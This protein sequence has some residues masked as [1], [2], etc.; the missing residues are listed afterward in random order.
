MTHIILKDV[1]LSFPHKICFESFSAQ[2]PFGSRIGIIGINGSGKSTL[3][4]IIHREEVP[5]DGIL[6]I[7]DDIKTA[8]VPQ[9]IDGFD[10]LSGGQL[11]NAAL[12]EALAENPDVLLL[13]EPTNHLDRSNRKSLMRLL[14]TYRGSLIVVTHDMDLLRTV[15]DTLWH[16]DQGKIHAFTGNYDDYMRERGIKRSSIEDELNQLSRQKKNVHQSLMKEQSRAKS[17]GAQGEKNIKQRKWPT[18]VSGA[19]ARRAEETSGIKKSALRG[20]R[21]NLF[22]K[23]SDLRLPEII[24]P[25]F[26]LNADD[27]FDRTLV[28]ISEGGVGYSKPVLSD[29]YL[30]ISSGDRVAIT[31]DNGS[32]KSTLIKGI[33]GDSVVLRSGKWATPQRSDIGYL[34]Q[35]YATLEQTHT[36]FETITTLLPSW[37]HAEIRRHLNDFLFRKNEEVNAVVETLSGGER[38]RLSLAQIAAKTPKLLILD[39]ITNNLDLEARTHVIDVLSVYPGAMIV[40]S[41]DEDFLDS[42]SITSFY[43]ISNGIII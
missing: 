3:L 13:D 8:Y 16:I 1:C 38:A 32:G 36:V 34:D 39:E 23:L 31:G 18:I 29:I 22:E 41:H 4:K 33:L 40:I 11:F 19:K 5:T 14:R 28:S 15:T 20:E 35:R 26:S 43:H 2:I 6:K 42:I 7:P 9:L 30:S 21:E 24:K 27:I 17:S 12:T 37:T 10:S 25:T